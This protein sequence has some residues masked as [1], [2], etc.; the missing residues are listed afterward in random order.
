MGICVSCKLN[1][2]FKFS[3]ITYS[4]IGIFEV[5]T[6]VS[7]G[8]IVFL[9]SDKPYAHQMVRTDSRDQKLDA[10]V[11]PKQVESLTNSTSTSMEVNET[12]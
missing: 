3:D 4:S 2:F 11:K 1:V 12:R 7:H 8:H 10:F 9:F 5:W 6:S